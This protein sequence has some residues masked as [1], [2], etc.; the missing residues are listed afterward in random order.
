MAFPLSVIIITKNEERHIE[1]CLSSVQFAGEI[2]VVDSGSQDMTC[3]LAQKMGATVL[4]H[5][6]P[7][8]G[9]QKKWA[10]EQAKY[11]WVLSIDADEV[12]SEELSAEIQKK[13]MELDPKVGYELPRKSWFMD[14]WILH[15]GWYPDRQ[16]RLYHRQHSQWPQAKIHERVQVASGQIRRLQS[17][18]LHYV[19]TDVHEQIETNNRYSSLLAQSDFEKGKRFCLSKLL[20]KPATKFLE[21]Y[22]LKLGFLDGFPGFVIAKNAGYSIFLRIVKLREIERKNAKA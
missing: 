3:H 16:L 22:L 11:D 9:P 19:F 20:L 5:D 13:F 21:C 4:K 14:R 2:L 12:V 6:W 10:T 8:Y 18:L 7:G 17:D 15:G 1:R